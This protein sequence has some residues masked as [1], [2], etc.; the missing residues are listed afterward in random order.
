[1]EN[2]LP[3]AQNIEYSLKKILKFI[4]EQPD[5]EGLKE[6]PKRII[7]SWK[8]LFAG[9]N[10][11]AS[12]ILKTFEEGAC[13]EI[14]I[15]KDIDFYSTCEHHFLPFFGK[16][17]I[18][19]LPNKKVIGISKLARL[20]E[21]Y[22]RRLQIQERMTSLIADDLIKF[23]EPKGVIV[24]C[25]STH[26]CMTSRGIKKKDSQMITSAVRGIFLT[27]P[28]LKNEFMQLIK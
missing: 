28:Q 9:Y 14:V 11:S 7:K 18:G 27:N 12:D 8:E 17:S 6:T 21:I 24:I 10:H 2:E 5:R 13:D 22:A 15:L 20:V 26:F 16:V 19:Y 25:K 1:M 23:L 3:T 4:G